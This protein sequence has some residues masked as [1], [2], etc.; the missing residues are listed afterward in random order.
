M[1]PVHRRAVLHVGL[2]SVG[3]ALATFGLAGCGFRLRGDTHLNFKNIKLGFAPRSA[4]GSELER[5][6]LRVPEVRVVQAE[7]D[8]EVVMDVLIDRVDRVGGAATSVGQVREINIT[9][10]LRFRLRT[11]A[12]KVLIPETELALGTAMT[13]TEE[14][15][16]AKESEEAQ[17]VQGMRRDLAAQVLRRF[18]TVKL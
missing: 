10:K 6:L 16:Q 8:A 1:S 4:M 5:Q 2:A 9:T 14:Q 12:G 7:K 18:E 15:A 17:I 13:Y 11:P 3:L